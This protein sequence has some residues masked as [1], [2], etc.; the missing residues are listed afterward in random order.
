MQYLPLNALHVTLQTNTFQCI[1]V[2]DGFM[3]FA[4]F[5]YADGFIQWTTGD[6]SQGTNG[7]GGTQAQIGFN[8][9]DRVNFA[10]HPYSQTADVINI[11]T[12]RVPDAVTVD[13]MLV[14]RVDGMVIAPCV[15]D[16]TGQYRSHC[17][18]FIIRM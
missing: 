8:A 11:A 10:S 12:S 17:Q 14:Y 9:G 6:A 3:S 2:S 7:L 15:D 18:A 13:G 1:L 4:I 5:L 16:E